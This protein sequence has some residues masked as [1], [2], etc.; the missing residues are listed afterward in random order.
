MAVLLADVQL[1]RLDFKGRESPLV[2]GRLPGVNFRIAD[3]GPVG[4]HFAVREDESWIYPC[5]PSKC[6]Q[7][8]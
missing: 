1:V 8:A 4:K 5:V 2:L 6:Q 7:R 3:A